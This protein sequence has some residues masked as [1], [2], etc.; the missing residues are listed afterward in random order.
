MG[1]MTSQ[2]WRSQTGPR[3]WLEGAIQLNSRDDEMRLLGVF[4]A[5]YSPFANY[6]QNNIDPSTRACA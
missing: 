1:Q 6:Y 3:Y 5:I 2:G 4:N